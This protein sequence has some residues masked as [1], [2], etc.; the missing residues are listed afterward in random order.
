[1]L[2]NIQSELKPDTKVVFYTAYNKY[3]LEALR[4]SAFDYLLKPYLPDELTAVI[5]R[6]RSY[7][8]KAEN[9][10]CRIWQ[11]G[12][13]LEKYLTQGRNLRIKT[14]RLRQFTAI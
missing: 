7:V 4:A 5:E 2:K 14:T 13:A 10:N 9:V 12:L 8:P 11:Y 1:L 3:L 6:Y